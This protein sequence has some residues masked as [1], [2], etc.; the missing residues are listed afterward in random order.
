[1]STGGAAEAEA[2]GVDQVDQLDILSGGLN[3]SEISSGGL[4]Q[5][6]VLSGPKDSPPANGKKG[7]SSVSPENRVVTKGTRGGRRIK[8]SATREDGDVIKRSRYTC[9]VC[10]KPGHNSRTCPEA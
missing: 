7:G 10:G 8:V 2:E 6:E 9:T 1:M 5:S 4:D 3:Q